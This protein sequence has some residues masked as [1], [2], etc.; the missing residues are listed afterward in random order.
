MGRG[1][2][3]AKLLPA[4][5]PSARSLGPA[6]TTCVELSKLSRRSRL[7]IRWRFSREIRCLRSNRISCSVIRGREAPT[8]RKIF[9]TE[10]HR[11][12][13]PLAAILLSDIVV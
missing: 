6:I 9:V 4:R 11:Q 3:D 10:I 2:Y 1:A 8:L 13:H 7:T 5:A 12:A